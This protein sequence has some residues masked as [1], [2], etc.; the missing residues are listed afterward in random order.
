MKRLDERSHAARLEIRSRVEELM[1]LDTTS[2][3]IFGTNNTYTDFQNSAKALKKIL[4][5]YPASNRP[6]ERKVL[7]PQAD[8][9]A[10]KGTT[11]RSSSLSPPVPSS[12]PPSLLPL[13]SQ[14]DGDLEG[15]RRWQACLG[16]ITDVLRPDQIAAICN[17]EQK[18][19]VVARFVN[20]NSSTS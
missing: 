5:K 7:S 16:T 15:S 14:R 19:K 1:E 8:A 4:Q 11:G 20:S 13:Q 12:V 18:E 9:I 6:L 17:Y 3:A 10:A 2:R